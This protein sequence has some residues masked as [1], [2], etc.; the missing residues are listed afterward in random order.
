MLPEAKPAP[1][2][3]EPYLVP[4]PEVEPVSDILGD[5]NLAPASGPGSCRRVSPLL[6]CKVPLAQS[7]VEGDSWGCSLLCVPHR[8]VEA[9]VPTVH[10]LACAP[11][12]VA[13]SIDAADRDGG[14]A[15]SAGE[16]AASEDGV[17][18]LLTQPQQ[19]H[20]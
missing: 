9:S 16:S 2:R 1:V 14:E 11:S 17:Q 10:M 8:W 4:R 20:S 6:C 15:V 18:A 13:D 12:L 3:R 7:I 19:R 5:S